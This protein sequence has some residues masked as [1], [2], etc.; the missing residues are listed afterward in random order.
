MKNLILFLLMFS[1]A[2]TTSAKPGK[3]KYGKYLIYEGEV[4]A[5]K[6]S[7]TGILR[8]NNPDNKKE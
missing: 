2:I 6:H 1:M 8:E 7:G 4:T 3:I 5:K